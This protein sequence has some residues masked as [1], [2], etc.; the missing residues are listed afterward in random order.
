MTH[1]GSPKRVTFELDSVEIIEKDTEELI[2]KG[3]V[4]HSTKAYKFSH[5]FPL[6]PPIALL[7]HANNTSKIWNERFMHHNF[8]YLQQLHNDKMVEGLPLI[9]TSVGVCHGFLV[10]KHPEKMYE[11]GKESRVA[12]TLD[13][14]HSDV[15]KP[16]HM[17][18]ING[19]IFF[20]YFI[21]DCSMFCWVYFVKQKSEVFKI[22]EVF[23][24]LIENSFRKN[25]KSIRSDNGGEYI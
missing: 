13:L 10:G 17:P 5:F 9:Q 22:F 1:I 18:S 24:A 21:D 14:I 19:S 23:K 8:K 16:V 6:S 12:S 11:V 2:A 25:I 20:L 3:I 7:T 4:N 15:S